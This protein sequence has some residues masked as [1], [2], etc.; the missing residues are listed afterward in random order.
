MTPASITP[1]PLSDV[2]IARRQLEG[3]AARFSR[4]IAEATSVRDAYGFYRELRAMER[5][6]MDL[7]TQAM[8]RCE[9]LEREDV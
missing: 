2:E 9:Q 4:A 5:L 1:F 6:L 8:Q 3:A 7:T